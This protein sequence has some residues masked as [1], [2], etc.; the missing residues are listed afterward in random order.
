MLLTSHGTCVDEDSR[1]GGAIHE[2]AM[3]FDIIVMR[4]AYTMTER[5]SSELVDILIGWEPFSAWGAKHI[6]YSSGEA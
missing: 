2:T 3:G 6:S 1:D 5:P 4:R